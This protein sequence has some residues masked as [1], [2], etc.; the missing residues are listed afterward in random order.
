[1]LRQVM[2]DAKIAYPIRLIEI[3]T[4]EQAQSEHFLGSP[5]FRMDGVDLWPESRTT[6]DLSCRV[7]RTAG[8]LRGVPTQAMLRTR[9]LEMAGLA[10][11]DNLL[12]VDEKYT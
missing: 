6:Y 7:Y 1:M 11:K 5:S 3:K 12:R 4:P 10:S 8:G 2:A 9:I